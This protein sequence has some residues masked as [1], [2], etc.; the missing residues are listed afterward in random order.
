[1]FGFAGL[2]LASLFVSPMLAKYKVG[3]STLLTRSIPKPLDFQGLFS[4]RI[5]GQELF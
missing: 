5:S 4:F 3:S 1:M 2:T